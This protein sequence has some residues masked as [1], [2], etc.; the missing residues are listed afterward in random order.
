MLS[1]V[2]LVLSLA[3]IVGCSHSRYLNNGS[4]KTIIQGEFPGAD[5]EI[6][7]VKKEDADTGKDPVR[8]YVRGNG[9]T[10]SGAKLILKIS[11]LKP[12]IRVYWSFEYKK[13]PLNRW[14]IIN[15]NPFTACAPFTF[16]EKDN[17]TISDEKGETR[18][19]FTG[20]TYAGDSFRVGAGFYPGEDTK[21]S[22]ENSEIKS[23]RLVVW[24]LMYLEQ[25]KIL[26]NVRFPQSTWEL[27]RSNLERLN[28]EVHIT[29]TFVEIDPFHPKMSR[30]FR[31]SA[32]D[33]RYG[34]GKSSDITSVLS[35]ISSNLSDGRP[36]TIN[37]VILGAISKEHD[38]L[39][40]SPLSSYNP[41]QP[42]D[43][44]Y[45]YRKK[46]VDPA[47][48]LGYGT[49]AAMIGDCPTVF[50]WADYW[51]V[52][53]KIVKTGFDRT[54]NRVILH[55]LGHHLLRSQMGKAGEILDE[56]GHLREK[57]TIKRSIMNGYKVMQMSQSGRF[58][59]SPSLVRQ[60]RKFIRNPTWHPQ[61]E[62]L[63]RQY[64]IPP[65]R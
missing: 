38:L 12:G 57:V 15:M 39:K 31:G 64:Y 37:V 58:V 62:R 10:Q 47:E 46:D 26:K 20:T 51:C 41:P 61:V 2:G 4:G 27:V 54:L 5:L 40:D 17:S 7:G 8:L 48:F 21:R 30:Y 23:K 52:F 35:K 44:N 22:F 53:H 32:N 56:K 65:R 36:E 13:G 25:P 16:H 42:A 9:K 28:I 63:I 60:E 50:V 24:K 14:G 49:A 34:P 33:P 3:V 1:S 29:N 59:L 11:G 19:R 43:Y 6:A 45:A 18:V 55:E